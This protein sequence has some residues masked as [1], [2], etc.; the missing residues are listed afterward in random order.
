VKQPRQV[1]RSQVSLTTV[2]TVCF[3]VLAV[4]A[5][6]LFVWHTGVALTLT[7]SAVMISVALDH[8]VVWLERRGLSRGLA[9]AIVMT[10]AFALIVGAV[11][12]LIPPAVHQAK[13]LVARWPYLKDQVSGTTIFKYLDEQF[14]LKERV[15][16]LKNRLPEI[17]SDAA[18]PVL[19]VLGG[20]VNAIAA[21]VTIFFLAVF[22]LVFGGRLVDAL[23]GEATPERRDRYAKLVHKIY[24]LIG[25]YLGG[26]VF[27]CSI[28]A[29]LATTM[30]AIVGLPFFLPLGLI[31]G[32]SSLV[33]YAG[34]VIAG[35][36]ISML[37]A[38]TAGLWKGLACA[39]YFVVYGQIEGNVLGPLIFRRT[40][41]V[42]PLIVLLSILFF[43]EIAGVF[44]AII[45]VP[46]TA[47]VQI[48]LREL[49]LVRRERLDLAKTKLNSPGET[50]V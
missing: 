10:G 30:L 8:V 5:L 40:V 6:V 38:V 11:F 46:V 37:A 22:M 20:L 12:L 41:H 39:I 33:P 35:I 36:S 17:S 50:T 28:N 14:Q 15:Q 45:A 24:D 32:F 7:A 48:V 26:L 16:S 2:F 43:G 44:G 19:S 42:N 29:T 21:A 1:P 13:Q 31:S 18:G 23:L 27:I 34:P 25:G 49:L 4:C 47:A 3:G 9:I